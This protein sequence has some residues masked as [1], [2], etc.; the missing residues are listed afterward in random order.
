MATL[1]AIG[2]AQEDTAKLQEALTQHEP[3]QATA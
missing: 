3:A 2:Y 1:V